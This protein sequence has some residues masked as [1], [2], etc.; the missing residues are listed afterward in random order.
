[1]DLPI[2]WKPVTKKE[3]IKR[4][5]HFPQCHGNHNTLT[6]TAG[7][8]MRVLVEA[9]LRKRLDALSRIWMAITR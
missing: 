8:L 9:A 2:F 6:H 1:M 3:I 7:K 4:T 5:S